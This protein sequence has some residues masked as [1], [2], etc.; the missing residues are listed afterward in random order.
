MSRKLYKQTLS[1]D[2]LMRSIKI[3]DIGYITILYMFMAILFSL[4]ADKIIGNFNEEYEKKKSIWRLTI[5][6]L[7]ILWIYGISIY[8]VRNLIEIIPFP[9]D[10]FKGFSHQ[11]LREIKA[12]SIYTFMFILLS[13]TI[14]SKIEFYFNYI[15]LYLNY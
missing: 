13:K 6:I 12:A 10:N 3:I 2:I 14:K 11:S 8:I 4:F 9:L 1:H 5:E 7:I 15:K